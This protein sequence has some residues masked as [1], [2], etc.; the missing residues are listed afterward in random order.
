MNLEKEQI[1]LRDNL[2]GKSRELSE[3]L[4]KRDD[5]YKSKSLSQEIETAENDNSIKQQAQ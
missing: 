1:K 5:Q 4:S 3:Y 2:E